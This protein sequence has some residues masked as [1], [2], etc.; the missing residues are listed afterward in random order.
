MKRSVLALVFAACGTSAPTSSV[1]PATLGGT[2]VAVAG[3][4]AIDVSLVEEVARKNGSD[5]RAAAD[6]LVYDAVLAQG[7]SEKKLD[8]SPAARE[9]RRAVLARVVTD[10]LA[11][12]AAARGAPTDAE[13]AKV[14]ARHW[15]DVDLPEQAHAVHAVVM[16]NDPEK[17]KRMR[18]VAEDLRRAVEGAK[19]ADDFI[20]RAKSVDAQGLEIRP[21][22]LPLFVADGRVLEGGELD[23]TFVAAAFALKPGETSAIVETPFGLHVIRMLERLPEKRVPLEERRAMFA[24]EVRTM[25]ARE[26]YAALLADA[27]RKAHVVIDPAADA[28]MSSASAP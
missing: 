21:E 27:K 18:A 5:A 6:A 15:R 28:L 26:A 20:A 3:S 17:K 19:D 7:A 4:V 11:S 13:V 25:R 22:K 12:D 16:T 9:G 24:D 1:A 23:M 2:T 14:T 8:R 10:R